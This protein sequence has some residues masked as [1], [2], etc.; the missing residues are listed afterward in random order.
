MKF[1]D[2]EQTSEWR[3]TR[4]LLDRPALAGTPAEGTG[5]YRVHI[6]F[7]SSQRA[8]IAVAHQ[9]CDWLLEPMSSDDLLVADVFETGIWESCENRYLYYVWRRSQNDH[10]L[11]EDAP[12]HVFLRHE[13]WEFATLLQMCFLFGWGV[14][15]R[16]DPHGRGFLVDHDGHCLVTA[17]DGSA[18]QIAK[19]ISR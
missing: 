4:A 9:V 10:R 11:V 18:E 2:R 5:C 7:E 16:S 1:L 15:A 12:G 14:S 6:S 8:T 19:G 17:S 13:T 3:K